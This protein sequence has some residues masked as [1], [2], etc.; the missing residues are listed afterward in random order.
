ML[1][2]Y[3]SQQEK[4]QLSRWIEAKGPQVEDVFLDRLTAVQN[5]IRYKDSG[6]GDICGYR[7]QLAQRFGFAPGSLSRYEKAY[8]TR[9]ALGLMDSFVRRDKGNS[10]TLC[11]LAQR[12][13][14]D[15]Q[16][17][18]H[19][20]YRALFSA[21]CQYKQAL[22]TSPCPTCVY[23][24]NSDQFRVSLRLRPL[25]SEPPAS[26]SVNEKNGLIIPKHYS[27]VNRFFK[28]YKPSAKVLSAII[29]PAGKTAAG[30]P[31]LDENT[32]ER[33]IIIP[34][35][36][37]NS[38]YFLIVQ[39]KGDSMEPRYKN[40]DFVVAVRGSRPHQGQ[41]SLLRI[42]DE[43]GNEGYLLKK[44]Y[45]D[46]NRIRLVSLNNN[47]SDLFYHQKDILEAHTVVDTI[48]PASLESVNHR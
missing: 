19:C 9:G 3:L 24:E 29:K 44:Y 48:I 30:S 20:S 41:I 11:L 1:I 35:K 5:M 33:P 39:V 18:R 6:Y 16:A 45:K 15:Y 43:D 42:T 17:S 13:L 34:S 25:C 7:K 10:R 38:E 31:I 12:F 27:S 23:N 22:I 47:Y 32:E 2:D 46:G 14:L 26:C 28:A 21:L 40:G 4:N 36:Y 8:R 37:L